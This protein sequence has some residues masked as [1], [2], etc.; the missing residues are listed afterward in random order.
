MQ[1]Q[2]FNCA[3][4]EGYLVKLETEEKNTGLGNN[5]HLQK[6]VSVSSPIQ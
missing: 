2:D 1:G 6:Q 3:L 4:K 5:T